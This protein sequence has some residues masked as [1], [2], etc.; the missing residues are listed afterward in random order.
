MISMQ[1][2][3]RAVLLGGGA[4]LG[5]MLGSGAMA[6]GGS[7][8]PAGGQPNILYILTD[9]MGYG[10]VSILNKRDQKIQTPNIDRI[11]REGMIF[12]DAHSGSAVC[13]P[14]R[15]GVIT[16]RYAWRTRLKKGV[17]NGYSEPLINAERLTVAGLLKKMGYATAAIGKWHLGMGFARESGG[18]REDIDWSKPIKGSPVANGFD[19]FY[20]IAASLDMPPYIYIENDRFVG[21]ATERY[22]GGDHCRRGAIAPG[23]KFEQ[24]VPTFTDKAI[25]YMKQSS[26]EGKPFFIYLALPG[27]HTP[28]VPTD[29]F[30]G[31][32]PLGKYA[33]YCEEIDWY[34]GKLLQALDEN[35]LAENT[36]VIFTSDN[37]CAPYIGVKELEEKGHYPSYIYRGYKADIFEGGHRVPFLVRWPG[38]VKPGSIYNHTICL[39]DLMATAAEITGQKLPETAGEDSVS[40]LPA[41][42]GSARP[43]RDSTIHHSINGSF[44]LRQGKWKLEMCGCSGGWGYPKPNMRKKLKLPP[45]QLYDLEADPSEKHNLYAEHPELVQRMEKLLAKQILDGRS[46]PGKPQPYVKPAKWNKIK[47][48]KDVE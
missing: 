46:T 41:L 23:F 7:S 12:T 33:D 15:Y 17:L 20:G 18:K 5:G 14:T 43:V 22:P 26:A 42:K 31:K 27:P 39:T 6:A 2:K 48:I 11:G 44:A 30:K 13:T 1:A 34:V 38:M 45:I 24:V 40:I 19:Y 16:G 36:L 8:A 35:K 32:N 47:W 10:D 3:F 28:L 37:G 9:D 4:A 25:S 29:Q 21:A